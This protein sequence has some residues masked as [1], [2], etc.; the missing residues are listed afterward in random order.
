LAPGSSPGRRSALAALLSFALAPRAVLAQGAPGPALPNYGGPFVPTPLEVV[1]R[2]LELAG[3]RPD[4]VLFDLGAGDGR[5]V[6]EAARQRGARGVGVELDP[7][8]V[9]RA[10]AAAVVAEVSDRV[11]F[12][13]GDVLH[14]DVREATV[15]MVY[16]LPALLAQLGPKLRA[17]LRPGTR[18]VSHDF[19]FENWPHERLVQFESEEKQRSMGFGTTQLRLYR[20]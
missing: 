11:R 18:I 9:E 3:V 13:E 1:E 12:V 16:L 7:V 15:V 8:L 6:I 17:D 20:T 4:D 14:A 10:R 2:M 5:V 19:G